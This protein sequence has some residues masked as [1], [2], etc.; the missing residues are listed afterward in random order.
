MNFASTKSSREL[1]CGTK[2]NQ[3]AVMATSSPEDSLSS[4]T[5]DQEKSTPVPGK[6]K[7]HLAS[8]SEQDV[9]AEDGGS[10]ST[11]EG[12]DILARQALDPALN[13]KMHLVNNVGFSLIFIV[14]L[15]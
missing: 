9:R 8:P 11:A 4:P 12:E 7:V 3:T 2:A 5:A 13:L 6:E 1:V 14:Y 10:I 15:G